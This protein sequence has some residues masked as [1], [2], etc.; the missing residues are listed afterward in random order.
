MNRLAFAPPEFE[1]AKLLIWSGEPPQ[2]IHNLPAGCTV[3][4]RL[5]HHEFSVAFVKSAR[6]VAKHTL[7]TDADGRWLVYPMPDAA[8]WRG[9]P[10]EATR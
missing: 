8:N 9:E 3:R 10:A 6:G 4:L 7:M 1:S 2:P 5:R